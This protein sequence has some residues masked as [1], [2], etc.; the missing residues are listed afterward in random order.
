MPYVPGKYNIVHMSD[1]S[2]VSLNI[3]EIV[4]LQHV[5]AYLVLQ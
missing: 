5:L 2:L 3:T 4:V 1:R